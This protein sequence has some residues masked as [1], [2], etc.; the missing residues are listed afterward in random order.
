MSGKHSRRE[1]KRKRLK[2]RRVPPKHLLAQARQSLTE[3]DGRR[4]LDLLRQAQHGDPALEELPLLLFCACMQRARQLAEKG[5]AKEATAMRTSAAQHRV[6]IA[7]QQLAEEDWMQYIRH[8]DGAEA[9]ADYADYLQAQRSPILQVER[10]LADLLVI[11]RCWKG[12]EVF[13]ADH[14]LRRD[15]G[16]VES[17][18]EAMDA[19]DWERA[20]G[21]LGGIG[22]RSPFAA[23]R[24][25]CKAMV[26]FGSGDDQ[27][28]RRILDLLPADFALTHVVAEWRRLCTGEGVEGPAAVSQALGTTRAALADQLGEAIHKGR[29]RDIERLIPGLAVA[30]YPEEPLQA[31]M[32]LL[33]VVGLAVPRNKVP[34]EA[35]PGLVQRLLPTERVAS[36]TAQIGLL[37]QQMSPDRWDPGP[38]A[39]YLD[40][41]PVAF[42]HAPDRAVARGRVLEAMART[43]H[44]V[45]L[46]PHFLP[47]EMVES[48][49]ALLDERLDD[50]GMVL[51]QLMTASLAADPDNR[52][53][54]RFLLDLLRGHLEYQAKFE[55]TLRDMAARFPDDPDPHLELAALHYA[56]NAYRR[57]EK[58]LAEGRKC[59]PHDERLLDMQAVGFL[60]S[61]DQSRKR[62]RFELAAQD[63]QRAEDLERPRLAFVLR[64]KRLL[65]AVVSAGGDAAEVVAPHLEG[66]PPSARLRTLALLL[67]DLAENSHIKNV[68]PEMGNALKALLNRQATV[69]DQLGPDAVLELIAPLPADFRILYDRL[70]IAPVLADWWTALMERLEGDHLLAFFDILLAGDQHAPVRAE[71]NRRLRGRKKAQRDPLLLFYLAVIRYQE[72]QDYD[73]RRF[74]E[75]IDA[76]DADDEKR[77]RAAAVRLASYAH[78]PLRQALQQFRFDVLDW[79][80]PLFGGGLPLP[81]DLLGGEDG[82]LEEAL[83]MLL[84]DEAEPL[85][86]PELSDGDIADELSELEDFIDENS[87]R[88]APLAA[89]KE[90]AGFLKSSQQTR[91]DLERIG[92]ECEAEDLSDDLSS[93]LYFLLFARKKKKKHR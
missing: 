22:R 32:A 38:A 37:I 11:Q 25:F 63:L 18:L 40:R 31:Q 8:S 70:Q 83:E 85:A 72:G 49:A 53:G 69:L 81:A 43:G 76:A 28:L 21:L 84:G 19:G 24:L 33:Q 74:V 82:S 55:K 58:S 29:L 75:V 6:S 51:A 13:A 47:A 62:G 68:K 89:L 35:I 90:F 87:L 93:E 46:Q 77:L 4:A 9:L 65:L 61:A 80:V 67:H 27:G 16:Q 12:L 88:G 66:L 26:C 30:L 56:K 17:S 3:G 36:A 5:L 34:I 45:G 86:I 1:R 41:L 44:K 48:L 64:V 50:P 7:F 54:Y 79:P 57:A 60:K 71:I 91:R 14:P 39:V 52:E 42:P 23:W 10:M 59:A 92:R 15:A 20:L 78:G 2:Q 73:S